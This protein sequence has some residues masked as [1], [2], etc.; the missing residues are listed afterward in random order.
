MRTCYPVF[1]WRLSRGTSRSG[2]MPQSRRG[3]A[4][5]PPR[6]APVAPY[7]ASEY[8]MRM[9]Q[10]QESAV[11]EIRSLFPQ[12]RPLPLRRVAAGKRQPHPRAQSRNF[13]LGW[14]SRRA[15]LR[16][17][18]MLVSLRPVE[19]N[20]RAGRRTSLWAKPL[21]P[22]GVD[23]RD[24]FP[25]AFRWRRAGAPALAPCDLLCPNDAARPARR[26]VGRKE[27]AP[28][29]RFVTGRRRSPLAIFDSWEGT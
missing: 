1:C 8:V 29:R 12:A 4:R 18:T 16:S 26:R 27:P 20:I 13:S 28:G 14:A 7:R 17:R 2:C 22:R 19:G 25:D 3:N 9:K 23:G 6:S 15:G 11:I 10:F 24:A 5:S 21:G